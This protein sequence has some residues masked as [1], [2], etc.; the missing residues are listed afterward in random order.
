MVKNSKVNP[1]GGLSEADKNL[2]NYFTQASFGVITAP[3]T[4]VDCHGRI[5]VWHLPGII[6]KSCVVSISYK[7]DLAKLILNVI[8]GLQY[9]GCPAE[10]YFGFFNGG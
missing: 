10:E 5:M 1:A 2:H 9:C 4:V 8:V 7:L 3:A 6:S